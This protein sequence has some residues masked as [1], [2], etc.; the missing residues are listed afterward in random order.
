MLY[1][2]PCCKN[3][4][5]EEPAAFEI[6]GICGWQDDGQNDKNADEVW[7]GPNRGLSLNQ[8]R[9]NYREYG[10]CDRDRMPGKQSDIPR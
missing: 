10:F 7:G 5:F 8:A 6:C 4:E 2:C 9:K 1:L 3:R